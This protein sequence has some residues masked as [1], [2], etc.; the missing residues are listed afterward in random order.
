MTAIAAGRFG[1]FGTATTT[2]ADENWPKAGVD[3]HRSA[4][5]IRDHASAAQFEARTEVILVLKRIRR[6]AGGCLVLVAATVCWQADSEA[7][8][9]GLFRSGMSLEQASAV[10]QA[11]GEPLISLGIQGAYSIGS[12]NGSVLNITF[13]RGRLFAINAK[14]SGGINAFASKTVEFNSQ[15]RNPTVTSK[16]GHAASGVF[17]SVT[18]EWTISPDETVSVSIAKYGEGVSVS[19]SY[20]AFNRMC[21]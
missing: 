3:S 20:S 15:F 7:F 4:I 14:L 18:L 9:Y 12:K 1:C 5:T 10:A 16:S 17:S 19:Q 6:N 13:C 11:L 21:R 8:E 2:D